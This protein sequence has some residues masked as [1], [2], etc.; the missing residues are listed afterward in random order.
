M[1]I[2]R[3]V[4]KQSNEHRVCEGTI[5]DFKASKY[6]IQYKDGTTASLT[7]TALMKVLRPVLVEATAAAPL[8][9][10]AAVVQQD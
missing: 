1:Y 2:G 7:K 9:V 4:A 5:T 8:A 6:I 3:L 10:A